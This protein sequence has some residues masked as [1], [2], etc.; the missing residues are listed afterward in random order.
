MLQNQKATDGCPSQK[1]LYSDSQGT[2]ELER[3]PVFH[4]HTKHID[5]RHHFVQEAFQEQ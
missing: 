4:T 3:N 2:G 5:I 1:V